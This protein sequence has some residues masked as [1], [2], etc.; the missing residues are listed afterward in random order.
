L[1]GLRPDL[2][3]DERFFAGFFAHG[4]SDDGGRE[5]FEESAAA[6]RF[7]PAI[8]SACSLMTRSSCAT[9][10]V[11][12]ATMLFISACSTRTAASLARSSSTAARSAAFSTRSAALSAISCSSGGGRSGTSTPC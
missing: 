10:P 3:R 1:P 7:N 5:E 11:S 4:A 2:D 12:A 9:C 8:S 6:W